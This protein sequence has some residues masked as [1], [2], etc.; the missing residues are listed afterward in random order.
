MKL[1]RNFGIGKGLEPEV[2]P[3][4][5]RRFT[6]IEGGREKTDSLPPA[7][8]PIPQRVPGPILGGLRKRLWDAIRF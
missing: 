5:I 4:S 8:Q 7:V 2:V 3:P 6:V 1:H